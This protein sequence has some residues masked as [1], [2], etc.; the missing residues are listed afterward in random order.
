MK[1]ICDKLEEASGK[2]NC[3]RIFLIWSS[4]DISLLFSSLLICVIISPRLLL[5][6]I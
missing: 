3:A 1:A 5:C 4:T 6:Q 2:V